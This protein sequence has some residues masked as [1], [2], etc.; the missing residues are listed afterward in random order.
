M[1][2]LVRG[3]S[4]RTKRLADCLAAV[5]NELAVGCRVFELKTP[6]EIRQRWKRSNGRCGHRRMLCRE[7]KA[8]PLKQA[9]WEVGIQGNKQKNTLGAVGIGSRKI[10]EYL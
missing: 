7:G 2:R 1:C 6:S 10:I 3:C 8:H 9:T 4:L 5:I